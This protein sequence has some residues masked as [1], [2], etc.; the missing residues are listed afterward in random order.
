VWLEVS[1]PAGTPKGLYKGRVSVKYDGT[2]KTL[3]LEIMVSDHVLP[4]PSEWSFHLDL[5]Q[6][7]YAVARYYDVPLWS[8]EHF[9]AM[10]PTMEMYAA[11]GGK[12][13]T[14]SIIQQP[15]NCQTYAPFESMIAKMKRIDGSWS[16]DY[17][18]FDRWIEFMMSCGVKEQIDCY[19]L[20]PWT[21]RFDYYDC[22]TNSVKY[23]QCEPKE[24]PYRE[25]ILPFLKDFAAHLKAKGWFDITCIAMD[26]RPVDQMKAALAV[27]KEADPGFR[28]AGAANYSIASSEASMVYD[29]SV[30]YN[31]DLIAGAPLEA[32]RAAGQK[33]TFYT[34]CA[35]ERPNTFTFSPAAESAM[36][37][38]HAAAVGY[39]GYLRWA[40]CSWPEDPM[41]DSRFGPWAAGD[42]YIVYP[43]A[44]SIRY[45]RLVE[46]IQAFEKV[47]ILR[48]T[49]PAS[50]LKD[51]EA[52]LKDCFSA[53]F[54]DPAIPAA[55][56]VSK[57]N[58]VLRTK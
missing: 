18:V 3:P 58:A 22:A 36:I 23:V 26:E 39:D 44:P 19:T 25:L 13:I 17:E 40:W 30:G 24:A 9:D 33:L 48:E 11:A 21:Y 35:P 51:L 50:E 46:G 45:E 47:R 6:N 16:Y 38:W 31:Y 29:M 56:L 7:P 57:A 43:G 54:L 27:L 34:C 8:K 41:N 4:A 52:V 55:L 32:R 12:V 53:N 2:V 5:W 37:G 1:V 28:I 15:W 14:A 49:L 42:T 20:V 10:R